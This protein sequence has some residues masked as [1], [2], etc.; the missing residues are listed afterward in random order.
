MQRGMGTEGK[1]S[2]SGCPERHQEAD[3]GAEMFK[4]V[5]ADRDRIEEGQNDIGG[6]KG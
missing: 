6:S 1:A 4:V 3:R 2:H 5:R